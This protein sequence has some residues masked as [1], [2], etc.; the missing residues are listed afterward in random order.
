ME[1]SGLCP[2]L[3]GSLCC[4]LGHSN[5]TSLQQGEMNNYGKCNAWDPV[6]GYRVA[7]HPVGVEN[8]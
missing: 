7:S 8:N 4:D 2:S 3:Y 1:C 6:M 5:L